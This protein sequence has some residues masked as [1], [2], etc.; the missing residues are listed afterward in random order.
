MGKRIEWQV[1]RTQAHLHIDGNYAGITVSL[2]K[3]RPSEET[4]NLLNLPPFRRRGEDIT[5][6]IPSSTTIAGAKIEADLVI[7]AQHTPTP[8]RF[9]GLITKVSGE[10]GDTLDHLWCGYIDTTAPHY[11]GQIASIQSCDHIRGIS[12]E[13]A[14]TNAAFIVKAVNSHDALVKALEIARE[15]VIES[16]C[17]VDQSPDP[18]DEQHLADARLSQIDAALTLA[19]TGGA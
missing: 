8:W 14:A 18:R 19:K 3:C 1:A 16:F 12:R 4:L 7:P 10:N 15:A 5:I 9:S 2:D 11:R 13:E 6:S 17:F